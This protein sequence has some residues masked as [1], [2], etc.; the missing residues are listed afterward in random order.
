VCICP[1]HRK[2]SEK[3]LRHWTTPTKEYKQQPARVM[4][5]RPLSP[6]RIDE[7]RRCYLEEKSMRKV[8][9][10]MSLPLST[11]WKYVHGTVA[12]N[13]KN[14]VCSLASDDE[15][16][17]G[18]YVG[19]WMG[20]GTQYIDRGYVIKICSNK[21]D[22]LLNR[23]VQRIVVRLFNARS[24]IILESSTNRAYVK[25]G[26]KFIFEFIQNY[27]A[28][29]GKKTNTVRLKACVPSYARD[30]LEG[31][32]LG[33][34]LSDGYLKNRF[35]F[36]VVSSGLAKNMLD[37]L[38][39]FGFHPTVYVH[40]RKKYGWRNLHMVRLTVSESERLSCFLD[41]VLGRLGYPDSFRCL[42][43]NMSPP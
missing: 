43:Y 26:S 41:A 36:N 19:L 23:F 39:M 27:V 16:L 30:F 2:S 4:S 17:L 37:M 32:L 40:D 15:R 35:S 8:G 38:G 28:Y 33:L 18:T 7:L 21:N 29:A 3:W 14:I 42:K 12:G 10:R 22:L 25:F 34:V 9:A 20:D 24:A 1:V 5:M 13:V 6:T 31:V 11:V